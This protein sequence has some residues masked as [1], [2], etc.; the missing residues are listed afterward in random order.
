MSNG[1]RL[2]MLIS[3]GGT[4]MQRIIQACQ[5]GELPRVVP[6]C[7]IASNRLAGGIAKA[8]KLNVPTK[9]ICRQDFHCADAFGEA[10]LRVCQQYAVDMVG[11]YG[12]LPITP[13]NFIVA[14]Q[15]AFTNQ[16]P[17][18]LDPGHLDFGGKGMYGRRV[19]AARLLFCRRVGHDFW[20]EATAQRVDVKVDKGSVLCRKPVRI[21]PE[22][23]VQSLQER[24]LPVEHAAQIETLAGFANG[25]VVEL[26]RDER[27]VPE[28]E[29]F[30]LFEAQRAA[31]LLFPHG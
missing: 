14:Y 22:D 4:T 26:V 6:V 13:G 7:V 21:L 12:W 23:D 28:E 16:H 27:L 30:V 29:K 9:I 25:R 2:A 8:Q 11:Q 15:Q 1:L 18:P 3:G 10:L 24:V 31:C 19:H 20:T 17:G 5:S